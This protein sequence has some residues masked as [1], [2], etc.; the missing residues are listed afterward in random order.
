[1]WSHER[2]VGRVLTL[3]DATKEV[4]IYVV[5]GRAGESINSVALFELRL[6]MEAEVDLLSVLYNIASSLLDKVRIVA[7][8]RCTT[9]LTVV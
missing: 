8:G 7:L 6:H 2:E 1:M 4:L 5:D 3:A 9:Q